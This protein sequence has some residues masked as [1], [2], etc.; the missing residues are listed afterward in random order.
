MTPAA[1]VAAHACRTRRDGVSWRA[2][3][4]A[5]GLRAAACGDPLPSG[6]FVPSRLLG[7][8]AAGSLRGAVFPRFQFFSAVCWLVSRLNG[9]LAA[10]LR[11]GGGGAAGGE[12]RVAGPR[13]R[14]AAAFRD[15]IPHLCAGGLWGRARPSRPSAS[16][17]LPP[18]GFS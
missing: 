8:V 15:P 13:G 12:H 3:C 10:G 1:A 6:R 2:P 14:R 18:K 9:D 7:G 16:P 11:L 5:R 4:E 17:E